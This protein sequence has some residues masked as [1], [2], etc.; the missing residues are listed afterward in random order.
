MYTFLCALSCLNVLRL[1]PA[2]GGAGF[3]NDVC[4]DAWSDLYSGKFVVTFGALGK[5]VVF[6]FNALIDCWFY[7]LCIRT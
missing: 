1:L 7:S 3:L 6:E 2:N 4:N 5:G